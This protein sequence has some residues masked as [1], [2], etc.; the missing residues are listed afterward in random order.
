MCVAVCV[1]VRVSLSKCLTSREALSIF[2]NGL[3]VS[4][5]VCLCL[6]VGV[7]EWVCVCVRETQRECESVCECVS[8]CVA[9]CERECV[10]MMWRF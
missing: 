2:C 6:W 8:V 4:L 3:Q 7:C 1:S 10:C 9:V 5:F